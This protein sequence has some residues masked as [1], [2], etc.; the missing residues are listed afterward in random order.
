M[1][2]ANNADDYALPRQNIFF[3]ANNQT[4]ID[5]NLTGQCVTLVKWFMAEMTTVPL[6]FS[7]RGDARYVG[8]TLVKQGHAVEV[9]YSDRKR[10][11]LICYEYGTYGHIAVQLSNGA[12]FESNV[13][14]PGVASKIVDGARVYAS[15]IGKE[16][17]SWRHDQHVYRI[18][19][20]SEKG[21]EIMFNEGDR[22]NIN[23]YLYGTD[24]GYFK[25]AVGKDWKT[26]MYFE[27]FESP[28]FK[29]DQLFNKGDTVE[30]E[31]ALGTTDA[32]SQI[33]KPWKAVWHGYI[34]KNIP[35]GMPTGTYLKVNKSDIID[36][37]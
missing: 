5:G 14:W 2:I 4:P 20:Y 24:M 9:P 19:S 1:A 12:I 27:I 16:S 33:G 30:V 15:R 11:D 29:V 8:K 7:A 32:E 3:P 23:Q 34:K 6:P 26:A 28:Q 13:N 18:K 37:Q 21:A 10:G 17:E 35:K 25:S 36:V 22:V 31:A